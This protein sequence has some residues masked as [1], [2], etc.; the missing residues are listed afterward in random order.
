MK[1]IE[2]TFADFSESATNIKKFKAASDLFTIMLKN[3]RIVHYTS[4]EP[5]KFK[6]WLLENDVEDIG[7]E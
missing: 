2:K 1:N 3:G 5:L 7:E 4:K 6:K